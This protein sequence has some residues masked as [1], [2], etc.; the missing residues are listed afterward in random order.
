LPPHRTIRQSSRAQTEPHNHIMQ[1]CK[2]PE[3]RIYESDILSQKAGDGSATLCTRFK[4]VGMCESDKVPVRLGDTA[5]HI[6]RDMGRR[7]RSYVGKRLQLSLIAPAPHYVNSCY[8]HFRLRLPG[9]VG[10]NPVRTSA[11]N[12][13]AHQE[14]S[15]RQEEGKLGGI[16]RGRSVVILPVGQL[17]SSF[18]SAASCLLEN[19]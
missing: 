6:F 3:H 17:G 13:G 16:R 2:S 12:E 15:S 19:G 8:R 1:S 5:T 7:N 14:N 11:R 9:P 18:L 4:P 10:S